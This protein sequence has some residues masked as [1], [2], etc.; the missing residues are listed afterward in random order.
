MRP[1]P[2]GRGTETGQDGDFGKGNKMVINADATPKPLSRVEEKRRQP[3]QTA[4]PPSGWAKLVLNFPEK[5]G[6]GCTC[7]VLRASPA[8]RPPGRR[9]RS[10]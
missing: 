5:D 2:R 6:T 9:K 10:A 4:T 8:V 3:S 7:M 1:I